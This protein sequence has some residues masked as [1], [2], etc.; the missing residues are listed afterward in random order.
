M[1]NIKYGLNPVES[2]PVGAH[3]AAVQAYDEAGLDFLTY[4]DQHCLTIPRCLW[5]HDICHAAEA[6]HIDSWFEP[7][8]LLT[9]AAIHTKN[10]R[11]G[12][13][14]SDV[15]RRPP[16]VLAQLALTLDHYSEGRFFL[17]LG[18]G[19]NKQSTPYGLSR[20]KPLGRIEETLKMLRIWFKT[21]EP[22]DY[23]GKFY[24]IR[25]SVINKL[26]YSDV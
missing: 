4:W 24:K 25:N 11:I 26:A 22:I 14:A 21:N 9:D 20:D 8:P 17:A 13:S 12:L 6:F 16:S 2:P 15:T 5:T 1:R 3:R 18:A 10:I 23:Y 7:W 19:E